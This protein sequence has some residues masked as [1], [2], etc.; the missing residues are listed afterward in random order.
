M[1][2]LRRYVTTTTNLTTRASYKAT[3]QHPF[4]IY[5]ITSLVLVR[6]N[7]IYPIRATSHPKYKRK[8]I[9]YNECD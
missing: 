4:V 1:E 8:K 2:Y 3:R 6:R 9:A 5:I 7:A